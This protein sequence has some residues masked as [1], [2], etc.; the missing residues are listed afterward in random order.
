MKTK[1]PISLVRQ[2]N[3][4]RV[5]SGN[6]DLMQVSVGDLYLGGTFIV[7][8]IR[9]RADGPQRIANRMQFWRHFVPRRHP[10]RADVR[11]V[12]TAQGLRVETRPDTRGGVADVQDVQEFVP[13]PDTGGWTI[14]HHCRLKMRRA[15]TAH[16][17]G[18]VRFPDPRGH[19]RPWWEIDDPNFSGNYGPSVPMQQD[20]LGI[21]EPN[22][23][24]DTFRKHWRRQVEKFVYADRSGG[25]STIRFHRALTFSLSIQN[26]RALPFRP[27]GFAGVLHTD[28]WGTL[29]EFVDGVPTYGHL[30]EWGFDT[31]FY[32][33]V[34]EVLRKGQVLEATCRIREVPPAVMKELLR[35]AKA[36]EP[37]AAEWKQTEE[38]P[39]YEEPVN[40][41]AT[42]WR[43]D[44]ARDAW[45]WSPGV[46][47]TWDR[48]VGRTQTGSL[49]LDVPRHIA[50][51]GA[52]WRSA[53]V[54]P[55]NFMNPFVP[56]A[57][58]RLRGYVKIRP[59]AR[60]VPP[61][62]PTIS[63]TLHQYGG[64]A[65][66]APEMKPNSTFTGRVAGPGKPGVWTKIETV[67][68]PIDGNVMA[69]TLG[70]QLAGD[71][72]AWFDDIAFEKLD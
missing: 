25:I 29:Y 44:R 37:T 56:G 8:N 62:T 13:D 52:S 35:G 32:R 55:T 2:G 51:D 64:P 22:C 67:T 5:V 33:A 12:G 69:A 49:R 17:L 63:I 42:S 23:G 6:A 66:F 11:G 16:E 28:G 26:R 65:M 50:N 72:T 57:R 38:L 30:C 39:V 27:G 54:G 45:A 53:R 61:C 48:R 40:H 9:F 20:W 14:I 46:G 36:V 60:S 41:F 43:D 68:T 59:T 4:C 19:E 18:L 7:R 15:M 71:G 3:H 31:H 24:P 34:P 21:Y 70:C 1:T 58:Y 10:D 47:A